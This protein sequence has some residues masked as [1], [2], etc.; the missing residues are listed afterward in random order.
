[1]YS[2]ADADSLLRLLLLPSSAFRVLVRRFPT[3]AK[4]SG[5][6]DAATSS[7]GCSATG[8]ISVDGPGVGVGMGEFKLTL[9]R[10]WADQSPCTD[11]FRAFEAWLDVIMRKRL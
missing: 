10:L 9:V 11:L 5:T 4:V 7:L 2:R 3:G 1:M 6:L 8:V